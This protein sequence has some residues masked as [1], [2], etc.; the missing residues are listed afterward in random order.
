MSKRQALTGGKLRRLVEL[1][2]EGG[3]GAGRRKG[4][5]GGEVRRPAGGGGCI[6]VRTRSLGVP[7]WDDSQISYFRDSKEDFRQH[8]TNGLKISRAPSSQAN[9]W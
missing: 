4:N 5:D 1:F 9:Y 7:S 8:R 6:H 2:G 3:A